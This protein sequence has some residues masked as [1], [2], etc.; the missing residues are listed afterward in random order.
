MSANNLKCTNIV[1]RM[2]KERFRL[3]EDGDRKWKGVAARRKALLIE[4]STYA[5]GDGTFIGESGRDYSPSIETL[6]ESAS[7]ERSLY[8]GLDALQTLKYLT[9]TR[10][11]HYQ[12]RSYKILLPEAENH[13][14]DQ[15]EKHL[16]N[17]LEAPAKSEAETA[18]HLPNETKTPATACGDTRLS[19][20]FKE[21]PPPPR[22]KELVGW[23]VNFFGQ[24]A[25]L[26]NISEKV[27][28]KSLDQLT[29]KFGFGFVR[30]IIE[31]F[32]RRPK[33]CGGF[34]TIRG[35]LV[36]LGRE[37]SEIFKIVRESV[38][39]ERFAA[40]YI[41][42]QEAKGI[43]ITLGPPTDQ[44]EL[45]KRTQPTPK[46]EAPVIHD[47]DDSFCVCQDCWAALS[48]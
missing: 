39:N 33:G 19:P 18:D 22:R 42:Q 23:A 43:K 41:A 34:E 40:A 31:E 32:A 27:V 8:R 26:E 38:E 13:L 3:P 45:P 10:E 21:P 29:K 1:K 11:S 35:L 5:N 25:G 30:P 7:S 12:R 16:P 20:S 24:Q 28:E 36:V 2:P 4:L 48:P 47:P 15:S 17:Q 44:K 37:A 46:A 14:P 9:W 6:L